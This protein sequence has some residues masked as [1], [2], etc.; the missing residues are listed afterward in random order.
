MNLRTPFVAP[1][2]GRAAPAVVFADVAAEPPAIAERIPA[3]P[4]AAT[5]LSSAEADALRRVA[6]H[7]AAHAAALVLLGAGVERASVRTEGGEVIGSVRPRRFVRSH[8]VALAAGAVGEQ[9]GGYD[10]R[11]T[12]P[13]SEADRRQLDVAPAWVGVET[14][15]WPDAMARATRLLEGHRD[16]IET[17]AMALIGAAARGIELGG[18][19]F[20]AF[21]ERELY[22]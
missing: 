7:E 3:A 5:S 4:A 2:A 14:V 21:V 9:L 8:A 16:A 15:S 11:S 22:G 13:G 10:V 1:F 18:E 17:V 19:A 20:E 12:L 6:F